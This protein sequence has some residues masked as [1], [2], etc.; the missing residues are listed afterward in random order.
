M[1]FDEQCN[2]QD[3]KANLDLLEEKQ[4]TAQVWMVAYKQKVASYYNFRVKSK[5]FRAGDLV[6]RRA[7]VSQPQNQEKLAPNWEGPYEVKEVVWTGTYYLKE[8]RGA[9]LSRP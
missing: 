4:E 2:P 9:D 3:L 6:L 8:L 7:T 1:A 5:A